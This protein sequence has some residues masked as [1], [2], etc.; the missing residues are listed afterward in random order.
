M[1]HSGS[2]RR[3]PVEQLDVSAVARYNNAHTIGVGHQRQ[4]ELPVERRNR[5]GPQRAVTPGLIG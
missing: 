3:Q 4:L 5:H 1:C 2:V